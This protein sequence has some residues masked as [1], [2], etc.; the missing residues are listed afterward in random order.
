MSSVEL[1]HAQAV[2]T[3]KRYYDRVKRCYGLMEDRTKQPQFLEMCKKVDDTY[4]KFE[5]LIDRVSASNLQVDET[6]RCDILQT[7]SSFE[8][9]YFQIKARQSSLEEH[10]PAPAVTNMAASAQ[11]TKVKLPTVSVPIFNG[12][13]VSFPS[14][15]SLYDELIH[16]NN[17]LGDIQKFSYLKSFVEGPA[18][19]CIDAIPFCA[20]SYPLAY[21]TL[22]ERFS[23]KRIL[24]RTQVNKLLQFKPLR[25]D[26]VSGLRDFLDQFHVAV[27]SL[28]GLRVPDLG[29]FIVLHLALCALDEKTS[30]DFE[31]EY[32][33][34]EFPSFSDLIKFVK[35]KCSILEENNESKCLP[36]NT[37]IATRGAR[38]PEFTRR[39]LVATGEASNSPVK[40]PSTYLCPICQTSDHKLAHCSKFNKMD[41]SQRYSAVKDMNLC[42]ACFSYSHS[43][44]ECRSNY[45]CRTCGSNNHH[46]LLH[47]SSATQVGSHQRDRPVPPPRM[48]FSRDRPVAPPKVNHPQPSHSNPQVSQFAGVG[49]VDSDISQ[50]LCPTVLLGTAVVQIQDV[51]GTWHLIR[52]VV[53]PGSQLTI[54]SQH[55][56]QTLNLPVSSCNVQVSGIGSAN[57]LAAKGKLSFSL[58]PHPGVCDSSDKPVCVDAIILPK[59]T[60]DMTSHVP[61]QVLTKFKHLQLADVTYLNVSRVS[62]RIDLLLGAEYFPTLSDTSMPVI[63]GK[64]AAVPSKLGWLLMGRVQDSEAPQCAPATANSLFIS[65]D[66]STQVQ[67]FWEL[68]EV[69]GEV[70]RYSP[71]ELECEEHFRKTVTRDNTGRYV[72]KLPFR[73]NSGNLGSNRAVAQRYLSSLERRLRKNPTI[74]TLY[75]ENLQTYLDENHMSEAISPAPYLLVHHGVHKEGSSTTKLRVVFNPN[76]AGSTGQTLAETLMVGPKLQLDIGDLLV[77]FRLNQVALTCDIKAMYRCILVHPED[78]IHQHILWRP[79]PT[80]E[81]KEFELKTVT[82]GLPPSP[83]QAQRVIKQLVTDEGAHFPHAAVT[84]EESI[85]VDDIVSGAVSISAAKTLCNELSSL[86]GA[87]GFALRKWA[88][89]HPEVLS[90]LPVEDCEKPHMLGSNESIKVLGIRWCP[91]SDSFFYSVSVELDSPTTTKRQVL[92]L[93]ASIYDV[94]GFLS[95]VTV[96]MKMFM[97]QVWL[98][99]DVSWDS[100]L[101]GTLQRKWNRLISEIHQLSEIKIP[102]FVLCSDYLSLD[103]IGF[104]DASGAAY[105]AVVYLRVVKPDQQ[106]TVHMLRA[107][108]K[109]APLKV[110]T[111]PKLELCAALLLVQIVKSLSFLHKKVK[112]KN[113]YLFSDSATVLAWLKT[114]PYLLKTF[115]ANRVMKILEASNPTQWRHVSSGDNSADLA[116]RG[117]LPSELVGNKLW[118]DGP[119]FLYTDPATWPQSVGE[120]VEPVP[121][122]KSPESLNVLVVEKPEDNILMKAIE[123]CSSLVRIEKIFAWILRFIQNVRNKAER[124]LSRDLSIPELRAARQLCVKTSQKVHFGNEFKTLASNSGCSEKLRVL[125]PFIDSS[126]VLRVGGRLAHA[127]IPETAKHPVVLSNK[128]HLS[129]L[130][131]R[132]YHQMS[133]HGGPKLVQS[134]IQRHFWIVS[135]RSLIRRIIFKCVPCF[136]TSAKC[137]QPY[138]ADIPISRYAQGR[139]FINVGIDFA[140]PFSLK[141]GPRRNSPVVKAYFCLFICMAT[142]AIHLELVSSLSTEAFLASLDRFIGRRG[143]PSCIFS[144]NGTNFRGAANYLK[145]VQDFLTQ[146]STPITNHLRSQE[147]EWKFNPPSAPNFGGLWEAGVKSVKSHLKQ[148]LNEQPYSF[149]EFCTLLVK[150]EAILNSRPLCYLST[151]PDD[152][153]DVLTP[154]HFLIGSALVA[155]PEHDLSQEKLSTLKRWQLVSQAN[156]G[157][158]KRW[159]RDYINTLVQRSKWTSQRKNLQI[160]DVVLVQGM[161]QLHRWPL[162]RIIEV[163]PGVDNIVRV[164]KVKTDNGVFIRPVCKLALLPIAD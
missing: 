128:C 81:V 48:N 44:N 110:Q 159:S 47:P 3:L 111:I 115:V 121:E 103:L 161:F 7:L 155:R 119:A 144:D 33:K 63:P 125:S 78:R 31:T 89:S 87:G 96:Y 5:A 104:G 2:E 150:I 139:P 69:P 26:S 51:V 141:T 143:L 113:T 75:R 52:A 14:W 132:H 29:E 146:S 99:K 20:S 148:V 80:Q 74:E 56:S 147:I 54:I 129:V 123:Q 105:A 9:Y 32:S 124:N 86:L 153:V 122:M 67:K 45:R 1:Q 49:N 100:P 83:Y 106:V 82:F 22:I 120:C 93:I 156:Q 13:I 43:R 114:E 25:N 70:N 34:T 142:K 18:R 35:N 127:P 164:V 6:S 23:K 160:N 66:L 136:R 133:I 101:P 53:D 19:M 98:I 46:T 95:P 130:L 152:G 4:E 27:Q 158:W 72:V 116:S 37:P 162:G 21:H 90:D 24:A 97:Q 88:S 102:R 57:T 40:A 38:N 71:E 60:N 62:S 61:Q 30:L 50:V 126:G 117:L 92:S 134:L 85:Y 79:D 149:E 163:F 16:K 131:I 58:L 137:I 91:K 145:E 138:M 154:G 39:S 73:E 10:K 59:I 140:G 11:T 65:S 17:D 84:L 12:D 8:G 55:L 157:F 41:P 108:T 135:G 107:R 76:V 118:F 42:F 68:E 36:Q 94:N 112:I 77:N 64:P 151:S 109:V 28:Q 15:K